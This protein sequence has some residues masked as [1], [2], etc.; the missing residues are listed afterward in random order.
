MH[1]VFFFLFA[2]LDLNHLKHDIYKLFKLMNNS[3][4]NRKIRGFKADKPVFLR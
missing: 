2:K 3:K 1:K 4:K